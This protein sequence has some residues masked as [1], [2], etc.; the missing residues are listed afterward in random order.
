MGASLL[1]CWELLPALRASELCNDHVSRV[2]CWFS[3]R[4]RLRF[5][6][7][8]MM[9]GPPLVCSSLLRRFERIL[10]VVAIGIRARIVLAIPSD[11]PDFRGGK[12]VARAAEKVLVILAHVVFDLFTAYRE[13]AYKD[14]DSNSVFVVREVTDF[15]N[16]VCHLSL[17]S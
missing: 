5:F 2:L 10:R 13:P 11:P 8:S 1:S 4:Y 6:A 14:V 9:P 15:E 16:S 17:S 7:W 12:R 3:D